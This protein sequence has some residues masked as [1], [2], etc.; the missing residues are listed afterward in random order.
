VELFVNGKSLGRKKKGVDTVTIPVGKKVSDTHQ[1]TSKYRLEWD[2]PYQPGTLRAVAYKN[3]AQVATDEVNTAGPPA[4][5]RL[6]P[7]RSR[8]AADG[9]DLSF[10]TVRVEDKDGNLCPS[11]ENLVHFK[12]EGAGTLKAVDNGNAATTE[13]FQAD[14]RKA[15]SGMALLVVAA[16]AGQPG[17]IQ[18]TAMSDGLQSATVDLTSR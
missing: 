7:D 13:S 3:G 6:I 11:A 10:L 15:F 8:I 4:R 1:F 2:V 14:F 5:V 12:V 18:V 9:R 17:A 16:R